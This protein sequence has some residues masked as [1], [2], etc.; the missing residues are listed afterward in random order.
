MVRSSVALHSS[1]TKHGSPFFSLEKL[2]PSVHCA[3]VRSCVLLG[4]LL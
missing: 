1:T 2:V 4:A 3:H